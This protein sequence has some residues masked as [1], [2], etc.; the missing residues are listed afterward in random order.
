MLT[1][2]ILVSLYAG[3]VG[4]IGIL[5]IP[6]LI[7]TAVAIL[8]G[9]GL[10]SRERE[11]APS[12]VAQAPLPQIADRTATWIDQQRLA[13]P[14]PAARIA[15]DIG[16]KIAALRPQLAT[17][18]DNTPEAW[19]L[20]RLVGEELPGLV[21]SYKRVPVTMRRE[22]RNGRVAERELIDGMRLLDDE[23]DTLARSIASADMDRLSSQKRYLELRYKG[24]EPA[25]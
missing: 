6:V 19:E 14:A 15:G 25:Q 2:M 11:I 20:R 17:L 4:P 23:I 18:D 8:F 13:L 5:S 3:L 7:L 24:D 10:F 22:N 16:Q 1:L 12:A 21:E 9:A